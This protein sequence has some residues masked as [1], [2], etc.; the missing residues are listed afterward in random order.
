MNIITS[1]TNDILIRSVTNITT[2]IIS[3]HNL[4]VWF[5]DYK[6]SNYNVYKKKLRY[7]TF[8]INY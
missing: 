6:N 2:S 8:I 5:I 3:T 7:L 1:I 4:F